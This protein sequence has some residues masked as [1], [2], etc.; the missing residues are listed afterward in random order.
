VERLF[1]TDHGDRGVGDRE[2]VL[3]LGVE[4]VGESAA[5]QDVQIA[6]DLKAP[7]END[8]VQPVLL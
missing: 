4:R 1:G 5:R 3:P 8:D 7:Y 2:E 6:F